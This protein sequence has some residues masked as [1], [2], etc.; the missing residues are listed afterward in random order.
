MTVSTL[1][2]P[3]CGA[4]ASQDAACC[5]YCGSPL[6][7]VT[8]P[9]CFGAMFVGSRFCAHCGA[10]S[11]R[12][13]RADEPALRCPRCRD[14]MQALT[15]GTSH[16]SECAACGGVWLDPET[17]QRLC[18]NR[19]QYESVVGI[20][21]SHAVA[22][23]SPSDTVTYIPCPV[24]G[25]LMNRVNFARSSGVIMDVCKKDGVWLDRGELQRVLSFIEHGG[26]VVQR[27]REKEALADEQRRLL[28]QQ[29]ASVDRSIVIA[30]YS[31]PLAFN[32][33][34]DPAAHLIGGLLLDLAALF[35]R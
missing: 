5:D 25:K 17:L 32:D 3:G 28:A 18:T 8:C 27:E 14:D 15:L 19:E 26:L 6:A 29:A 31:T 24:C 7:T 20:L 21:A 2:C 1:R 10:E 22:T 16:L 30:P 12:E 9:A 13:V 23:V 11:V 35:S 4:P 33:R 34:H